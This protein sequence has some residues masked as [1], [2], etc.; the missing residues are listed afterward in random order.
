MRDLIDTGVTAL[1]VPD[2]AERGHFRDLP[3][4]IAVHEEQQRRLACLNEVEVNGHPLSNGPLAFPFNAIIWNLQRG[5]FPDESATRIKALDAAVVL[6]SEMDNGMARTGQRHPTAEIAAALHMHYAYGVEFIE[7]GLGN[8]RERPYCRDDFNEKGFHGNALMASVPLVTPFILKLSGD[9]IWF[10]NS[11][12]QPRVGARM[13]IG[14]KIE[15]VAGPFVAISVHLESHGDIETRTQQMADIF[16]LADT[17]FSGLP[18]LIGGD[19]NTGN[20]TGGDFERETLFRLAGQKGFQRHG[21]PL[22]RITT[23]NSLISEDNPFPLKLDWF[24]SRGLEVGET[25]VEDALDP[26]GK[27]LS[28]H[29]LVVCSIVG[30]TV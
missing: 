17:E 18:I 15:T 12:D 5:L 13:A 16:A 10:L 25:R 1:S 21:G 4:T 19:L 23:R 14:A 22:D 3:K 2:Q 26:N 8:E 30:F 6:L 27:P 11:P 28:D 20:R 7:L 29:D 9:P 24:L